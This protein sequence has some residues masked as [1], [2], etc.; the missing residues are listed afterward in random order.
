MANVFMPAILRFLLPVIVVF[1]PA[2][3][4]FAQSKCL[5]QDQAKALLDR[6][7]A[8]QNV[9]FNNKLHDELRKL[10]L[11]AEKI[12]P[13]RISPNASVKSGTGTTPGSVRS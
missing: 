11:K 2:M 4:L 10:A 12:S 1:L 5:T 8:P 13:T 6:M 9:T 3:P 7:D